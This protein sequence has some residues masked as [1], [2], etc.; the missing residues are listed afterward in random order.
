MNSDQDSPRGKL[1]L[2]PGQRTRV[3]VCEAV[4]SDGRSTTTYSYSYDV[5]PRARSF[6]LEHDKQKRVVR[7][8][9]AAGKAA[10]F[11]DSPVRYLVLEPDPETGEMQPATKFGKPTFI[12]LCR[13]DRE[14]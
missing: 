6:T 13:E 1:G 3:D 9:D 4:R 7:L 14:L 2:L 10:H 8:T 5:D 12:Y 11:R